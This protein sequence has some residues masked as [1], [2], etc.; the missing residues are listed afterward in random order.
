MAVTFDHQALSY[1]ELNSRANKLARYLRRF[2]AGPEIFVGIC[3]ER[4]L[5]MIVG[6]L[7]IL[8]SGAA[9]V[10]LD[11]S[12]PRQRLSL[13]VEDSAIRVLVT[14]QSL[15]GHLGDVAA[16]M[17]CIDGDWNVIQHE[18]GQNLNCLLSPDNAAYVIYTSGSTGRPKGVVVSHWNVVRLFEATSKRFHFSQQDVWTL[19]HS[20]A[21][22]FSVWELWGALIHGGRLV[23][24]PFWV[25][26]T[27]E[28]YQQLLADEAVT[29][30]NQTPSAM[31][32]LI[33]VLNSL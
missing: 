27:P 10:P 30:V 13:I 7:G 16:Q 9:Y 1:A 8:K 22:D 33:D 25:S 19:F 15:I 28:A 11:P 20:Y 5:D 4:S 29:I 6:L 32:Q 24:V 21:F 17:V 14:Q 12:Y 26:R 31:R 23:V 18:N 2:G 3:V